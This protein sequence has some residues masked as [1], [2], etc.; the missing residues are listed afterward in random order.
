MVWTKLPSEEL[1]KRSH[2]SMF[3]SANTVYIVGGYSWSEDKA[4]KLFPIN[5]VTRLVFSPDFQVHIDVLKINTE[6]VPNFCPFITGFACSGSGLTLWLFGGI[7]F[8]SYDEEKENLY[9]FLPPSTPRNKVPDPSSKLLKINLEDSSLSIFNGPS[10]SGTSNGSL[11][12]LNP[13][14]PLLV[15]TCDPSLFI[16]RPY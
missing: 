12:I 8:P 9:K 4:T 11:Q 15:M 5:E 1:L 2:H 16:F 7:S 14:E 3:I 10:D 6:S 13:M